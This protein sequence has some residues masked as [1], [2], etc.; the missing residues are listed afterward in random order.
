MIGHGLDGLIRVNKK[1][2]FSLTPHKCPQLK[3]QQK[4]QQRK[5]NSNSKNP[6]S[7]RKPIS[8]NFP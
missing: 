2:T 4:H 3:T 7:K 1:K 8:T 6:A 5:F